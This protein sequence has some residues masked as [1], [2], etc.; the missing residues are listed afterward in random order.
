MVFGDALPTTRI[1]LSNT[2]AARIRRWLFVGQ[3]MEKRC[4]ARAIPGEVNK[5]LKDK[6]K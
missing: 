1:R 2:V 4:K 5:M 6:L 3:V